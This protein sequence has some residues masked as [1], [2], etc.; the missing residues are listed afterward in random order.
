MPFV[1]AQARWRCAKRSGSAVM[2]A[3]AVAGRL[4][5]IEHAV[6]AQH[7]GHADA[8]VGEDAA[9][10]AGLRDAMTF[11]VAPGLDRFLVTEHR[12]R[13]DLTLVG[14]AR[15]ALDRDEA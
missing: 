11:E 13:Q 2:T 10:A 8:I 6:V 9:A 3:S 4:R 1:Q 14:E 12:E 7:T 15:E 5:A